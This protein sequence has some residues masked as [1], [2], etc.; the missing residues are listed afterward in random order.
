LL[1]LAKPSYFIGELATVYPMHTRADDVII[2]CPLCSGGKRLEH[3]AEHSG[4]KQRER[5]VMLDDWK[6]PVIPDHPGWSAQRKQARQAIAQVIEEPHGFCT[7]WGDFGGGKSLAL[8]I[9][10]NE[11]RERRGIDGYYALSAGVLDHIRTLIGAKGDT[12]AF[13]DRLLNV[14]VLALDEVDRFKVT[15][16]AHEKLFVLIDTR[17]RQ[18]DTHLTLFATNTDPRTNLPPEEAM[19]YLYSRMRE[20]QRVWLRGDMR[21]YVGGT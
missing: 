20:G 5:V 3:I 18:L 12:S 4:L 16:W 15:D 10:V 2:D 14:P 11:L 19:G 1:V 13:W 8:R 17:Y 21:Q 9:I 7:F 6:V